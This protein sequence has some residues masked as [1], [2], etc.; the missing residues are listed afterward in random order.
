VGG[1]FF[2]ITPRG[3]AAA[4][5]PPPAPPPPPP[6]LSETWK[7]IGTAT[8]ILAALLLCFLA[9][10]TVVGSLQHARDQR[11]SYSEFRARLGNG[12]APVGQTDVDGHLLALGVPVA[13]ITIPR[14]GIREVVGEGTTAGVLRS[15]PGHRRDTVLPGQAGASVVMG[16]AAA[17]GGPFGRLSELR[18]GDAVGVLTGQGRH[19]YRVTGLR[20][21][22]DPLPSPTTAK[23]TLTLV[24]A[25][26]PAY[27]PNGVLRV[28]TQLLG[29]AAPAPGR[30]FTSAGLAP[31]EA[32]MATEPGVWV[33][34]VLWSQALLVAA[35]GIVWLRTRWGR[36]QTWVV[37]VPVLL[38]V[39][40]ALTDQAARLLP[41]LV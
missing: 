22:G 15:G 18:V 23:G 30:V 32:V 27:L 12:V 37:G 6:P 17:Y 35:I 31:S 4:A 11:T 1:F 21:A 5:P 41:N 24:T 14:L 16:R 28:D 8:T 3:G 38:A 20:R 34:V 9:Q 33:L 13:V 26:G 19:V 7:L 10:I 39:G 2:F 29:D 36:W 25:D 40:F